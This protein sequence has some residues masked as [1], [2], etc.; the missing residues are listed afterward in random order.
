MNSLKKNMVRNKLISSIS[1]IALKEKPL[2]MNNPSSDNIRDK[3]MAAEATWYEVK[4]M[5]H[6]FKEE[7]IFDAE[8]K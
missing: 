3:M 4:L 7:K 8:T 6:D 5:T 2:E 1:Y